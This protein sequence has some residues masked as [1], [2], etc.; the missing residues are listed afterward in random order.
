LWYRSVTY[1]MMIRDGRISFLGAD[2]YH[3]KGQLHPAIHK[4]QSLKLCITFRRWHRQ[5]R[6]HGPWPSCTKLLANSILSETYKLRNL[7][8]HISG[9]LEEAK[10]FFGH[11]TCKRDLLRADLEW[12]LAPLRALRGVTLT[13]RDMLLGGPG[14]DND[15]SSFPLKKM[16][17][18][19]DS[20]AILEQQNT[21]EKVIKTFMEEL[22]RQIA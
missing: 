17:W 6:G 7:E 15:W 18:P 13:Y 11:D 5:P 1:C 21:L 20:E 22:A 2:N 12:N 16:V 3:T 14:G 9:S 19:L 8:L 4:I 10:T